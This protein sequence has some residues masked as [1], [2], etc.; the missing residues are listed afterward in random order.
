MKYKSRHTIKLLAWAI[1][2]SFCVEQIALA[3]P[4]SPVSM[5]Q[6]TPQAIN[7]LQQII[8]NPY[9]LNIPHEYVTLKEVHRGKGQKL[10]IHIQ[11]AHSNF[12]AQMNL[13]KALNQIMGQYKIPLVLAEGSA[14]EVSLNSIKHIAT[15]AQ[16]KIAANRFLLDGVIQGEEFLNLTQDHDMRIMGIEY[17]DLYQKNLQAFA[18][19]KTKRQDILNQ[20]HH[21]RKT[22]NLIKN[23]IYPKELLAYE[24]IR[25]NNPTNY[26]KHQINT[27]LKLSNK[28]SAITNTPNAMAGNVIAMS[29]E[30]RRT[31]LSA[32]INKYQQLQIQESQLNF[33]SINHEQSLLFED[34][35]RSG[36]SDQVKDYI[37]RLK[38]LKLNPIMQYS[39]LNE[40]LNMASLAN[41]SQAS[42]PELLGYQAYLKEFTELEPNQLLQ[43]VQKKEKEMYAELLI[44]DE[45]KKIH[46]IDQYLD[47]IHKAFSIQLSSTEYQQLFANQNSFETH[48]WQA[49]V[50]QMLMQLG[51]YDD[52]IQY[53]SHIDDYLPTLNEFYSLVDARD[54]AFIEN[55][56]R[57]MQDQNHKIAFMI[58]GGY[59]TE[60]LT[61]LLKNEDTSYIVLAPQVQC[62][63]N[64]NQYEDNLLSALV[65]DNDSEA[66][67][68]A[69]SAQQRRGSATLL[70]ADITR[71]AL[72]GGRG[73]NLGSTLRTQ[74]LLNEGLAIYQST[75]SK[76]TN[77]GG[78]DT[79]ELFEAARLSIQNR[80]LNDRLIDSSSVKSARMSK[81]PASEALYSFD[82]PFVDY[83]D[84]DSESLKMTQQI[85]SKVDG[86][87]PESLK[88][89]LGHALE[90]AVGHGRWDEKD[91]SYIQ[92]TITK[93]SEEVHIRITNELIL[94]G[95]IKAF[96]YFLNGRLFNAHDDD[97]EVSVPVEQHDVSRTAVST[98]DGGYGLHEILEPL[99][100]LYASLPDY[101]ETPVP[102]VQ[103]TA[104]TDAMKVHFDLRIPL[105]EV[106]ARHISTSDNSNDSPKRESRMAQAID[107]E[108]VATLDGYSTQMFLSPDGNRLIR[109][110]GAGQRA[111]GYDVAK[112][113]TLKRFDLSGDVID[114]VSFSDNSDKAI[115][116]YGQGY[117]IWDMSNGLK[118]GVTEK[119]GI[120]PKLAAMSPDGESYFTSSYTL[121]KIR[122]SILHTEFANND[123]DWFSVSAAS[124]SPDGR[125]IALAADDKAVLIWDVNKIE[126]TG[127]FPTLPDASIYDLTRSMPE[128]REILKLKYSPKGDML[129]GSL[130]DHQLGFFDVDTG[131]LITL[132]GEKDKRPKGPAGGIFVPYDPRLPMEHFEEVFE[133]AFTQLIEDKDAGPVDDFAFDSNQKYLATINRTER[134]A[135]IKL[136]WLGGDK[137]QLIQVIPI[138]TNSPELNLV[139]RSIVFKDDQ[140][141]LVAGSNAKESFIWKV[142]L[143]SIATKL[144]L[145]ETGDYADASLGLNDL[146]LLFDDVL[147]SF[148]EVKKEVEEQHGG[149]PSISSSQVLTHS[150]WKFAESFIRYLSI[151]SSTEIPWIKIQTQ[152]ALLEWAKQELDRFIDSQDSD[153]LFEDDS[154]KSYLYKSINKWLVYHN[155]R[156]Y[157]NPARM[158]ELGVWEGYVEAFAFDGGVQV[159][160][161]LQDFLSGQLKT[162][163]VRF[164]GSDEELNRGEEQVNR[165]NELLL[166]QF[167]S[168]GIYPAEAGYED[169]TRELLGQIRTLLRQIAAFYQTHPKFVNL[170]RAVLQVANETPEYNIKAAE[171]RKDFFTSF[172]KDYRITPENQIIKLIQSNH[173]LNPNVTRSVLFDLTE[174][175]AGDLKAQALTAQ[176]LT[177]SERRY[178]SIARNQGLTRLPKIDQGTLR[179]I[180]TQMQS[181][182]Y[183]ILKSWQATQ[184]DPNF[185]TNAQIQSFLKRKPSRMAEREEKIIAAEFLRGILNGDNV[186]SDTEFTIVT[187]G[188]DVFIDDVGQLRASTPNA[189]NS[190]QN[191][192]KAL[193]VGMP[194]QKLTKRVL[195]VRSM[196]MDEIKAFGIPRLDDSV[197][198]EGYM[199]AF[200]FEL[201]YDDPS[202]SG[203]R[204]K[205]Y[206]YSN[207]DPSLEMPYLK[208]SNMDTHLFMLKLLSGLERFRHQ[209]DAVV[210]SDNEFTHVPNGGKV[211]INNYGT[212]HTSMPMAY[213]RLKSLENL[214]SVG[215]PKVK[216]SNRE[217]FV[218]SMTPGEKD[219]FKITKAVN[220]QG[221]V[222]YEPGFIFEVHYDDFKNPSK[223]VKRQFYSSSQGKPYQTIK[224]SVHLFLMKALHGLTSF[225]HAGQAVFIDLDQFTKIPLGADT[226]IGLNGLL[227]RSAA[228]PN[229]PLESI[230]LPIHVVANR[231]ASEE[232]ELFM[233]AMTDEEKEE[234]KIPYIDDASQILGR[235]QAFVFKLQYTSTSKGMRAHYFHSN[236]TGDRFIPYRRITAKDYGGQD[237]G[238]YLNRETMPN[239]PQEVTPP[240][241]RM[242]KP[243]QFIYWHNGETLSYGDRGVLLA[244]INKTSKSTI[245][246]ILAGSKEDDYQSENI[247]S[248]WEL[249]AANVSQVTLIGDQQY[250]IFGEG[251][252]APE[253]HSKLLTYL[254]GIQ[255]TKHKDQ[256]GNATV[257]DYI[258]FFGEAEI[259][260]FLNDINRSARSFEQLME[261]VNDIS[262][263]NIKY[264]VI[265]KSRL[266][267]K[268]PDSRE[269]ALQQLADLEQI[270]SEIDTFV[271]KAHRRGPMTVEELFNFVV[272]TGSRELFPHI[273]NVIMNLEADER[274]AFIALAFTYTGDS[275][276]YTTL[277]RLLGKLMYW[278]ELN[279]ASDIVVLVQG[280]FSKTFDIQNSASI[281][282]TDLVKAGKLT[283]ADLDPHYER[284]LLA[285]QETDDTLIKYNIAIVMES[286]KGSSEAQAAL[287]ENW[288][289][290]YNRAF[291][292][293][294]FWFKD[295]D[296]ILSTLRSVKAV[297]VEKQ[298][299]AQRKFDEN[300]SDYSNGTTSL[301]LEWIEG[302]ISQVN[303]DI[304]LLELR[305]RL[306]GQTLT[307]ES[308]EKYIRTIHS[309]YEFDSD[310]Q[311]VSGVDL[312]GTIAAAT[313]YLL[314]QQGM[315][316]RF[317]RFNT[318]RKNLYY[319]K[320]TGQLLLHK[321]YLPN[322][323]VKISNERDFA[324]QPNRN[325]PLREWIAYRLGRAL[326]MNIAETVI[327]PQ[328]TYS[329]L[330]VTTDVD[331]LP[332]PD[333][334]KA[335]SH[336]LVFNT[337][338]RRFDFSNELIQKS[339]VGDTTVYFDHDQA[340]VA[341]YIGINPYAEVVTYM[342]NTSE[343]VW[344]VEDFDTDSIQE[345][346]HRIIEFDINA[347]VDQIHEDIPQDIQDAHPDQL[348][349]IAQLIRQT[350]ATIAED[351]ARIHKELTGVEIT[352]SKTRMA[353][354]IESKYWH[355]GEV[356]LYKNTGV[357]MVGSSRVGKS[358]IASI[359]GGS[360]ESG[361]LEP[362][363]SSLWKLASVGTSDVTATSYGKIVLR[364]Q[365]YAKDT[366]N[367]VMYSRFLDVLN[368]Y[369]RSE[370][371]PIDVGSIEIKHI[372]AI[373]RG[374]LKEY[375]EKLSAKLYDKKGHVV[376][377]DLQASA[378]EF[379][380]ILPSLS[381]SSPK[382]DFQNQLIMYE[383]MATEIAEYIDQELESRMADTNELTLLSNGLNL[384]KNRL[385][386][387]GVLTSDFKKD[388][389]PL[390]GARLT[391][392]VEFDIAFA[393]TDDNGYRD[394]RVMDKGTISIGGELIEYSRAEIEAARLM[395][396][397]S[398]SQALLD[399]EPISFEGRELVQTKSRA[400][401]SQRLLASLIGQ[402]P[403]VS[404]LAHIGFDLAKLSRAS[405]SSKDNALFGQIVA[406]LLKQMRAG[407]KVYLAGYNQLSIQRQAIVA[408]LKTQT[409]AKES[410]AQITM[411]YPKNQVIMY[412]DLIDERNPEYMSLESNELH[413]PLIGFVNGASAANIQAGYLAAHDISDSYA[414]EAD[415]KTAVIPQNRASIIE[416]V[417][418]SRGFAIIGRFS[419]ARFRA[420]DKAEAT[421][422]DQVIT[423][424]SQV[425]ILKY[426]LKP[427]IRFTQMLERV[428]LAINEV[429]NAA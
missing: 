203:E 192:A 263:I 264:L 355:N 256:D 189:S 156:N 82:K 332:Q 69:R 351:V 26:L 30:Q 241:S 183:Q 331:T 372:V 236:P 279:E 119:D 158:T 78:I 348:E 305:K 297:F 249:V 315:R 289:D 23:R 413:L 41:I 87:L 266:P 85:V 181:K 21:S 422:L 209:G 260:E 246:A 396:I 121:R 326:G 153:K 37:E 163:N 385:L 17:Q 248:P 267:S 320:S 228:N 136:Y 334:L 404:S 367:S 414:K 188:G 271:S 274:D 123:T 212:M 3:A 330:S 176:G 159:L 338:I 395:T 322:N 187:H 91:E 295:I 383:Q 198:S 155:S 346:V 237:P 411:T 323:V 392:G 223:R 417:S 415:S 378:R 206:F 199:S 308:A 296:G 275:F 73:H 294:F 410:K 405:K 115:V 31:N 423:G 170:G 400:L 4:M 359:L 310:L 150:E 83:S 281:A 167:E 319:R 380:E 16:W 56:N 114:Q 151:N 344:S 86:F 312:E 276:R 152:I 233:R 218:R 277:I 304:G 51:L 101:P 374:S 339:R 60:H 394:V 262:Q 109:F 287:L 229:N 133:R 412:L 38:N 129:I 243:S 335:E 54:L 269:E 382:S 205:R 402:E 290:D 81:S 291:Q 390:L 70:P 103:W 88:L 53:E 386:K 49:F 146:E 261:P 388:L 314:E 393:S 354:S 144:K 96:P 64:H 381:A 299:Q 285:L 409:V 191:I 122:D 25:K 350:Q 227:K 178:I 341:D 333:A 138:G 416:V 252:T 255:R 426:A 134:S 379:D 425:H 104:D 391:R 258:I 90:N 247:D 139:L 224:S 50:N 162:L 231:A 106:M 254:T 143:Q 371:R 92:G 204:T 89:T 5:S 215:L 196:T 11:D 240:I 135:R 238:K 118:R 45:A 33:D 268:K 253:L 185:F 377:A 165:T 428:L 340:F 353:K 160:R 34:I 72:D 280:L 288:S 59:H 177:Q 389:A 128:G 182:Y 147:Q 221:E 175:F 22:I 29:A 327:T 420:G 74:H 140:T 336:D 66:P 421:G 424:Q 168:I 132:F 67:V 251:L 40:L 325:N 63:T 194:N 272:E 137:P 99:K 406:L 364:G 20:L 80:P 387:M 217:L 100:L 207:P 398:K 112:N 282:L 149:R 245:A 242:A 347:F 244:G 366:L 293:A 173:A 401:A 148:A 363:A 311:L 43:D 127:F 369:K 142:N 343:Q 169:Q 14:R 356:L 219:L 195:R 108:V 15:P 306:D 131:E 337:L 145:I 357:L 98:G 376:L 141:I 284:L 239:T 273:E 222:V 116:T 321:S 234:Y 361:Y 172:W 111:E 214:L 79:E 61:Q 407:D 324:V 13:S 307:P 42:Y 360:E 197:E 126:K 180:W 113:Q 46:A 48:V 328:D 283:P 384:P 210:I 235:K 397:Q 265:D 117:A 94:D 193:G 164:D 28:E 301:R 12:G 125:N 300:I 403:I 154:R 44:T 55:A 408:N 419:G 93:S 105:P 370:L 65:I 230:G 186:I 19:L 349:L 39:D 36:L 345:A 161:P 418:Q 375:L 342:Q 427:L 270:A 157:F 8:E 225:V 18:Q 71:P 58:T 27:L 179:D 24:D 373:G 313:I 358:L 399:E 220:K 259:Q 120:F 309:R 303:N 200:I 174:V 2:L 6:N 429:S 286:V 124:F 32:T 107:S 1:V 184:I 208:I 77:P 298:K 171:Q 190:D 318:L 35:Q 211:Y 329:V 52:L 257:I 9:L 232:A 368:D 365:R 316:M 76:Q 10:I 302:D 97:D 75:Y 201:E 213:N 202:M 68:I 216:L 292:S 7:S 317:L 102:T 110:D 47:L 226:L 250:D 362:N 57:I 278:K 166:F 62:E 95:N 84:A 130:H 352:L